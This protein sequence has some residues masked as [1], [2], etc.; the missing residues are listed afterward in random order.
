MILLLLP[1]RAALTDGSVTPPPA[2]DRR[3]VAFSLPRA[4]SACAGCVQLATVA[5]VAS[6]LPSIRLLPVMQGARRVRGCYRR[7]TASAHIARLLP[8][9]CYGTTGILDIYAV[10]VTTHV[11]VAVTIWPREAASAAH[12]GVNIPVFQ[13]IIL[14]HAV[15]HIISHI[16]SPCAHSLSLT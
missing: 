14:R 7:Y 1:W 4:R 15:L 2:T 13:Q 6:R 8:A 16:A 9:R 10:V 11:N 5:T 12:I 3:V